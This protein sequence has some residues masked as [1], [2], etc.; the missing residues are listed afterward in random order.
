LHGARP[1]PGLWSGDRMS[2]KVGTKV[3]WNTS[4]GATHGKVVE[5]KTKDFTLDG[6]HFKASDD[7]PKWV[8]ESDKSGKRAA[9]AP[10]ALTE[11][12]S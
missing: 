2:I 8:V 12:K 10:S 1:R 4:Q 3:S 9:H 7:E 5:K 11:T 6:Q